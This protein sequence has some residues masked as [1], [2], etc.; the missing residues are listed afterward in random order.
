MSTK[1]AREKVMA[2]IEHLPEGLQKAALR[3]LNA[4]MRRRHGS[5]LYARTYPDRALDDGSK[6]KMRE[7]HKAGLSFRAC[8]EVFHLIPN[9]GNDAQRCVRVA[10]RLIRRKSQMAKQK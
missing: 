10:S 2:Q 1:L 3:H 5:G 9:S 4:P 8:E 6:L 7:L